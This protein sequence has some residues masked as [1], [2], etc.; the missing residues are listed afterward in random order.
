MSMFIEHKGRFLSMDRFTLSEAMRPAKVEYGINPDMSDGRIGVYGNGQFYTFFKKDGKYY[1]VMVLKLS[2]E[3]G[4][5]VSE[6]HTLDP[7]KFDDDRTTTRDALKVF[8]HAMYV[9]LEIAKKSKMDQ[10]KFSPANPSLG[11]V[12]DKAVVNK[13]LLSAIRDEGFSYKGKDLSGN[14]TFERF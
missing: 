8:N 11:K 10:I 7:T 2:S 6:T 3:V 1:C 13:F 5:A 4:F 9:I 14:H 12:Y